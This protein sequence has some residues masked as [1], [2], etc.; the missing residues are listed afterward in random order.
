MTRA[1]K[2]SLRHPSFEAS[3]GQLGGDFLERFQEAGALLRADDAVEILLVPRGAEGQ[4]DQRRLASAGERQRIAAPVGREALAPDEA[5]ALEVVEGRREGRLVTP[6][7]AAELGL[8][9]AGVLRD[10]C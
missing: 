7:G 5:A 8:A 2:A 4:L 1:C 9:D 10:E 3:D 6:V